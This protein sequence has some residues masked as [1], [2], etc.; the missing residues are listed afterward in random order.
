MSIGQVGLIMKKWWGS[1]WD[2]G[3]CSCLLDL[4]H[5]IS[6]FKEGIY[7]FIASYRLLGI[8]FLPCTLDNRINL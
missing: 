6:Q 5:P 2:D 7:L 1:E 8:I 3:E 4:N